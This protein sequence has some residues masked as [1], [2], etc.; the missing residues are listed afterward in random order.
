M[1]SRPKSRSHMGTSLIRQAAVD[2]LT[3]WNLLGA[4][5]ARSTGSHWGWQAGAVVC[6]VG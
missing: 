1:G 2:S 3:D 6:A 5:C 4:K